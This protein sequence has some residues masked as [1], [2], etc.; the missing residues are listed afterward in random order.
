MEDN[1]NDFPPFVPI[2]QQDLVTLPAYAGTI[3]GIK[4]IQ[5]GTIDLSTGASGT[6][7]ITAVDMSKTELR[8]LGARC[9]STAD[10]G[11]TAIVIGLMNS[12]TVVASR[13]ASGVAAVAG[14]EVTEW[15]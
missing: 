12:T 13:D 10:S 7:T 9:G 8:F 1:F 3:R 14:F 4:S 6:A 11:I 5:R 15:A 2:G